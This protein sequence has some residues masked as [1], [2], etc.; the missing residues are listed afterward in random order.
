MTLTIVVFLCVSIVA[1]LVAEFAKNGRVQD[2]ALFVGLGFV[3]AA[4]TLIAVAWLR[5]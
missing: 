4:L 1:A 3:F 2:F 5:F